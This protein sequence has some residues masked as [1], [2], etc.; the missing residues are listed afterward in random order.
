MF[1]STKLARRRLYLIRRDKNRV[2]CAIHYGLPALGCFSLP[3]LFGGPPAFGTV[4]MFATLTLFTSGLC[5]W[6]FSEAELPFLMREA[7]WE[8]LPLQEP[9][10]EH[11]AY[12]NN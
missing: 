3:F 9:V 1:P 11:P 12:L 8:S 2:S 4:C 7:E 6:H 5:R 10:Q